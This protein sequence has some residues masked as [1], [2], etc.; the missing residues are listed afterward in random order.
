VLQNRTTN[1]LPTSF[2]TL[3]EELASI[4]HNTC[5]ARGAD[6]SAPTFQLITSPN[7]KQKQALD[8]IGTTTA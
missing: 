5:R 1:L 7:L 4:V 3:M 6:G 8:L 2:R